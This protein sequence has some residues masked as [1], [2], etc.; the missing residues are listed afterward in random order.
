MLRNKKELEVVVGTQSPMEVTQSLAYLLGE[1]RPD[2]KPANPFTNEVI[3]LRELMAHRSGLVREP[4]VGNYFEP[5][6][7]TLQQTIASL[8]GTELVHEPGTRVKYSNAGVAVVGAVLEKTQ[9]EPFAQY[10][11]KAVLEPLGMRLSTFTP[12]PEDPTNC[13]FG[14]RDRRTLYVTAGKSLYRIRL[15]AEGF[16]VYWPKEG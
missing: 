15:N 10:V 2:F 4:P 9:G 14:G 13:V 5:G 6:G 7:A 1:A 3:T 12:T 16:A 11:R 8:N